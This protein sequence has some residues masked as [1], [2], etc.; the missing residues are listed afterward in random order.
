[1]YETMPELPQ[2]PREAIFRPLVS[3]DDILAVQALTMG[4]LRMRARARR[5]NNDD[6]R[7]GFTMYDKAPDEGA[8]YDGSEETMLSCIVRKVSHNRWHMRVSFLST[9]LLELCKDTNSREQFYFDWDRQGNRMAW[10]AT[11]VIH[12]VDDDRQ[13]FV[14][15]AHPVTPDECEALKERMYHVSEC[16]NPLLPGSIYAV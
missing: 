13:E 3:M 11:N 16:V 4:Y 10:T 8:L 5:S 7:H 9:Q 12:I 6:K 14:I 1:M 2:L 15:N